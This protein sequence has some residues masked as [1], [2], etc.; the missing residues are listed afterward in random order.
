MP[1][2]ILAFRL[3]AALLLGIAIGAERQVRQRM[4]GLRT[5]T[6]VAVGAALFVVLS[7]LTPDEVSPTRVAA[8]VVSGIGFLGAGVIFKEGLS[9]RGL[10]TAATLWCSAAVGVLCGAGFV[11]PAVVGT[12]AILIA[13]MALRP[14]ARLINQQPE[15]HTETDRRFR[16][17]V[18]CRGQDETDIRRMVLA[19]LQERGMAVFRLASED[20]DK[21]N[22]SYVHADIA[23]SGGQDAAM[24]QVLAYIGLE[25]GI[26]AISWRTLSDDEE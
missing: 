1:L 6:L 22:V 18:T 21:P 2:E 15:E 7:E 8:Q 10:N 14:V 17:S 9:V 24:E 19:A 3:A 12:A 26:S 13:N 5:N 4:A 20:N 11:V 23:V 16:L 25:P